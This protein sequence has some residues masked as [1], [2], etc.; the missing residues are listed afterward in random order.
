MHNSFAYSILAGK[1]SG[2]FMIYCQ[3]FRTL[4]YCAVGFHGIQLLKR[5]VY[6]D[7]D[8]LIILSFLGAILFYLFWEAKN[9]Y[10][11]AF[12]PLLL[13]L[14]TQGIDK[15]SLPSRVIR[16]FRSP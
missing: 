4:I 11:A 13:I 1:Y 10:S 3:A 16:L 12:L 8:Y 14:T 2:L 6:K 15:V 5:K 9:A 7:L